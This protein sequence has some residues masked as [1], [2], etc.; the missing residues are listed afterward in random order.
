MCTDHKIMI[1]QVCQ[2]DHEKCSV[3][4]ATEMC[5]LI[6]SSNV[7]ELVHEVESVYKDAVKTKESIDGNIANIERQRKDMLRGAQAKYDEMVSK[8]T[9]QLNE[10]KDNIEKQCEANTSVLSQHLKDLSVSTMQLN[11]ILQQVQAVDRSKVDTKSFL[12]LQTL[13]EN[14]K[15]QVA[16]LNELTRPFKY[17]ETGFKWD[18]KWTSFLSKSVRMGTVQESVSKCKHVVLMR[19]IAFPCTVADTVSFPKVRLTQ[20]CR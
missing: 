13:A 10:A 3:K 5:K 9:Q 8:C 14:T 4:H 11:S 7:D 16:A 19:E 6:K 17:I 18:E 2:K 15:Q 12:K 20:C 1:C